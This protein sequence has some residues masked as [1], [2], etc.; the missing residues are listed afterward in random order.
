LLPNEYDG[1]QRISVYLRNG[2]TTDFL[3]KSAKNSHF[4]GE[5]TDAFRSK[6]TKDS[7]MKDENNDGVYCSGFF[8][9]TLQTRI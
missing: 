4:R 5:E 2:K 3:D 1:Q 8:L 6:A 9:S 7:K